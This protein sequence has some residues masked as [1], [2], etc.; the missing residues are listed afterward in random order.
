[1]IEVVELRKRYGATQALRGV[2]LSVRSGEILGFVGPNGAGKTTTIKVLA[3]LEHPDEGRAVVDGI[4]VLR[5]PAAARA[6]IGYMPDFFGV[7][8]QLSV[9]EYLRFYAGCYRIPRARARRIVDDLLELVDLGDRRDAA[10]DSLSRGMKQRLCLA[11]ALVHD[12]AVLLLDEPASGLDPRARVE[13][14]ELLLELRRM[15]KTIVLSSHILPELAQICSVF[16]IV[17]AG[18]VVAQGRLGALI[19]PGGRRHA[20]LRVLGDRDTV[21]TDLATAGHSAQAGDDADAIEVEYEGGDAQAAE[22]LSRLHA[23]GVPVLSFM[24][25]LTDLEEI[26]LRLTTPTQQGDEAVA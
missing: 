2:D 5:D 11:R 9:A 10:V 20:Q 1:M 26:F 25:A 12:P 23:E 16:A 22:L 24:P 4:D 15:G 19:D 3:T 17:D 8:D 14:R 18:R 6:R 13:M 21:L 7:Y